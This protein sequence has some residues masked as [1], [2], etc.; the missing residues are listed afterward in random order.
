MEP[1]RSSPRG[2]DLLARIWKPRRARI[3]AANRRAREQHERTHAAWRE[4]RRNHER[5]QA[6]RR[7][8]FEYGRLNAAVMLDVDLPEIEDMPTER[9]EVAARGLRINVRQRSDAQIR[10]EYAQHVHAV[11]F[12]L[13]GEVFAT[14]PRATLATASGSS[15][16]SDPAT[17]AIRDDYLLSVR[18]P[19]DAWMAIRFANLEAIDV[20]AAFERFEVRRAMIRGGGR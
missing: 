19:R 18:V 10:R 14:L 4:R 7:N 17:G 1:R 2:V 20:V 3:D 8:E 6:E 9:A 13:I 5:R 16:R 11:L 12:R 15:Q